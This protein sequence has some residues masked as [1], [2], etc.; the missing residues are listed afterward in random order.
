VVVRGV[1][2]HV[3]ILNHSE[4]EGRQRVSHGRPKGRR[5]KYI[6]FSHLSICKSA[7]PARSVRANCTVESPGKNCL[8]PK[9]ARQCTALE[10]FYKVDVVEADSVG[11][12]QR[13][14]TIVRYGGSEGTETMVAVPWKELECND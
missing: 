8:G 3:K 13:A 11:E 9:S 2:E 12:P 1:D 6:V 14:I 7:E 10:N 5:G 4:L